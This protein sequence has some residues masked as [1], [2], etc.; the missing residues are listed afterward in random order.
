MF[1]CPWIQRG[2]CAFVADAPAPVATR[3]RPSVHYVPDEMASIAADD[4]RTAPACHQKPSG[5]SK[6][7]PENYYGASCDSQPADGLV[8]HG[9][10]S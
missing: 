1:P 7:P 3:K 8:N 10:S 6:T 2:P 4:T 5:L 9:F